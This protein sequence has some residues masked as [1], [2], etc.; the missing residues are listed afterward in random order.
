MTKNTST[1][2]ASNFE[3]V[4]KDLT[5]EKNKIEAIKAGLPVR[6]KY[7]RKLLTHNQY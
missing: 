1:Y 3:L 7:I 4:R 6:K 2:I 5:K